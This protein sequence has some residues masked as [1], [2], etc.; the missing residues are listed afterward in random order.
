MKTKIYHPSCINNILFF[1]FHTVASQEAQFTCKN[2]VYDFLKTAIGTWHVTTEDR[3]SI[4]K[5]EKNQG[6][7]TFTSSIE[8]CGN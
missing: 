7:S 6:R 4:G 1:S 5:Y 8:G 3:I 2:E